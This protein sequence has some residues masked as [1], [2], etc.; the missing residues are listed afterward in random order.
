MKTTC[1]SELTGDSRKATV[2][3]LPDTREWRLS[4]ILA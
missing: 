3:P 2:R 1:S 4:G